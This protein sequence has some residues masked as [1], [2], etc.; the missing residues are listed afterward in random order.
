MSATTSVGGNP[1]STGDNGR[2]CF[3]GNELQGDKAYLYVEFNGITPEILHHA[4]NSFVLEIGGGGDWVSCPP[5]DS[6]K[7][8]HAAMTWVTS[9]EDVKGYDRMLKKVDGLR[10]LYYRRLMFHRPFVLRRID[11]T[12]DADLGDT[13]LFRRRKRVSKGTSKA[14]TK[15]RKTSAGKQRGAIKNDIAEANRTKKAGCA[16]VSEDCEVNE[17][18]TVLHT[19]TPAPA[20]ATNKRKSKQSTKELFDEL[21]KIFDHVLPFNS[22]NTKPLK[23]PQK[24]RSSD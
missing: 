24:R 15:K 23:A 7:K 3:S 1:D 4:M 18:E 16:K 13:N 5:E 20:E 17:T 6:I 10:T 19:D 22:E 2:I 9:R 21:V 14:P 8:N 12:G 11:R